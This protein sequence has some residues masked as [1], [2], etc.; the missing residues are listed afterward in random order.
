[1]DWVLLTLENMD[2][3]TILNYMA[4]CSMIWNGGVENGIR[5]TFM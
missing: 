5:V 4:L 1:M 2:L 3:K